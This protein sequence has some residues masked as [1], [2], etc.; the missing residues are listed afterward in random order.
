MDHLSSAALDWALTHITKFGDSDLFPV[1]FEFDCIKHC[2]ERLRPFLEAVDLDSYKPRAHRRMLVPK[3]GGGFRV[4]TQ[5]DPLDAIVYAALAYELAPLIEASRVRAHLHIACSFRVDVDPNG[6]LFRK[7]SGWQDFHDRSKELAGDEDFSHV[8]VAD[9]ADFYNQLSLHRVEGALE[10]AGA[11]QDRARNVER[12]LLK[13]TAKQ[14]RG[15]PVG[16]AASVLLAEASLIDVDDVL[17]RQG[18]TFTRFVDDFRIFC[19]SRKE[20]IRVHHDLAEYLYTSHRLILEP[21]KTR[22]LKAQTF[23]DHE[24]QD[25]QEVERTAQAQRVNSKLSEILALTGY[26]LGEDDLLDEDKDQLIR[27]NLV[28]LFKDCV[29]RRPLHLGLARHL[30]RRAAR[31]RTVV[32]NPV[33]FDD[34]NRLASVFREVANYLVAAVPKASARRRGAEIAEFVGSGDFGQIPFIRLWAL[35]FFYRRPDALP[36]EKAF[37]LANDFSRDLGYRQVALMAR[38]GHRLDWLRAQKESWTNHRPWD[39]RAII[40]AGSILPPSERRAWLTSIEEGSEDVLDRAVA[41]FA[42]VSTS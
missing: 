1:P 10:T 6:R 25:P 11:P 3:P 19:R 26:Q 37:A 38:V 29:S 27:D 17:L 33:V 42:A 16:P 28:E 32:L 31:L 30:L 35:D 9:I 36:A 23:V 41:Q 7:E 15:L 18:I 4:A 13:L 21:W 24:L 40:F 20:A 34:L 5:L 22:V 14:S 8:L 2:W 12:F 39:R